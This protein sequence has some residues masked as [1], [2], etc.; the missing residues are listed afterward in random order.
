MEN[1]YES[2]ADPVQHNTDKQYK[3]Q[4]YRYTLQVCIEFI[5]RPISRLGER[6]YDD[7]F[8]LFISSIDPSYLV[9]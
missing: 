4:S 8:R 2:K 3:M 7:F 9:W 5:H 6:K 1:N